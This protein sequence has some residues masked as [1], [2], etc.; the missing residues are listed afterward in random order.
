M[1]DTI[2]SITIIL[3]T[4][5]LVNF[6]DKE[7][8]QWVKKITRWIPAILFSFIFPAIITHVFKLDLSS[9]PIFSWNTK[10][11][12]PVTIF[13]IMASMS[14]K[15]LKIVGFKPLFLFFFGSLII[16]ITPILLLL[17]V[18]LF[19]FDISIL[20]IENGYWKGL[21]PIVGS[22]IG[23]SSSMLILKEY[24]A[25]NED[26]FFSVLVI[27]TIIQNIVMVLLFQS[28][29]QTKRIDEKYDL[30]L[31]KFTNVDLEKKIRDVTFNFILFFF[32]SNS[33]YFYKSFI[34]NKC[35]FTVDS[36]FTFRQ[37]FKILVSCNKLKIRLYWHH[38][39]YGNHWIKTKF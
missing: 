1:T 33:F 36:R 5:F 35:N 7:G 6:L 16:S 28:I 34:F 19:Q 13:T 30:D 20:L 10:Y 17:G 27:D 26:L 31:I 2:L 25:L 38:S 22:W 3:I 18:V 29:K 9:A 14:L 24:I 23:G 15:Q 32:H 12:Y 39:N 37:F 11:L 8:T 21:I 4:F